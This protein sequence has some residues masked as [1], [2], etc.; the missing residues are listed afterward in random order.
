MNKHLCGLSIVIQIFL[1]AL[2]ILYIKLWYVD[3][4]SEV[5]VQYL[6]NIFANWI[7]FLSGF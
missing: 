6:T 2:F 4:D 3:T 5:N 7:Y 1:K